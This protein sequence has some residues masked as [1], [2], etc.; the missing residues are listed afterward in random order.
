MSPRSKFS[1]G[2]APDEAS[3]AWHTLN[4]AQLI[5]KMGITSVA[6]ETGVPVFPPSSPVAGE[7]EEE[8]EQAVVPTTEMARK[9]KRVQVRCITSSFRAAT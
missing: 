5:A 7:P 3:L 6:K 9:A 1:F 2:V 4:V 8:E